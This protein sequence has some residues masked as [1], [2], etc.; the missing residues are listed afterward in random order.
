MDKST[1]RI[2]EMQVS[3]VTD[4]AGREEPQKA[5]CAVTQVYEIMFPGC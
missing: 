4:T 3:F 2:L 5:E 1:H